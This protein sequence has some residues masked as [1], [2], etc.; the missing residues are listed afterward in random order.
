[1]ETGFVRNITGACARLVSSLESR[2][3]FHVRYHSEG[4]SDDHEAFRQT[5]DGKVS[6]AGLGR[7]MLHL[8]SI[9]RPQARRSS[10]F[11][12]ERILACTLHLYD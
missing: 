10:M 7:T 1:M 3:L 11:G 4:G 6:G 5:M 8:Y 9:Y 12:R 2:L